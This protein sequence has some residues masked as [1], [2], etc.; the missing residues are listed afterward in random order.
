MVI[1]QVMVIS[2][3]Q[4][5][6]PAIPNLIYLSNFFF[7]IV[8]DIKTNSFFQNTLFIE[9]MTGYHIISKSDTVRLILSTKSLVV[10]CIMLTKD[11][12][13]DLLV[14]TNTFK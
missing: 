8:L 12:C 7:L 2:K 13:F 10:Q 1:H 14:G 9:T 4:R 3:V 11:D 5:T 6:T